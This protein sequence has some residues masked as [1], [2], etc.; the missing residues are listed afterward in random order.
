MR[1]ENK[2][3]FRRMLPSERKIALQKVNDKLRSNLAKHVGKTCTVPEHGVNL[4]GIFQKLFL[5]DAGNGNVCVHLFLEG[6]HII[7]VDS[8]EQIKFGNRQ[9]RKNVRKA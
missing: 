3:E 9:P 1:F 6:D 4:K 5:T 7:Y 2:A 8:L